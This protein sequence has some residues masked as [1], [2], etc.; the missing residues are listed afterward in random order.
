MANNIQYSREK[1]LPIQDPRGAPENTG[2]DLTAI[3]YAPRSSS[4]SLTIEQPC[5]S[6]QPRYRL[7]VCLCQQ[8]V[9][10]PLPSV[11]SHIVPSFT[12]RIIGLTPDES[13]DILDFLFKHISENHDLQVRYKWSKNDIAIWDN[14]SAF[15]TAT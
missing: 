12:K 5:H 1:G 13:N 3:Q 11:F 6:H 14:R 2:K 9:C 4:I 10:R 15:H 7:E 8:S